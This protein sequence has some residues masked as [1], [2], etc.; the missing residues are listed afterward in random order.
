MF[1]LLSSSSSPPPTVARCLQL[2]AAADTSSRL[3]LPRLFFL[4]LLPQRHLI[5][6]LFYI[7]THS[8]VSGVVTDFIFAEGFKESVT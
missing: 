2:T 7:D 3:H 1:S 5:L 6:N 8:S 4:L